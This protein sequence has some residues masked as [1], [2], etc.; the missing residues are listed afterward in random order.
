MSALVKTLH[1]DEKIKAGKPGS[2]LTKAGI[3]LAVVFLGLSVILVLGRSSTAEEAGHVSKWSRF[4]FAYLTGWCFA[5]TVPIGMMWIILL[6]FLV[7]GRWV[8][9][10][11]RICEA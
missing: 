4:L 1:P 11:R 9:A 5:V 2:S 8:T 3:G 7:R 10:V 6:H